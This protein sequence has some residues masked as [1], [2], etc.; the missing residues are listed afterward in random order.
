M[1]E[2]AETTS[3]TGPAVFTGNLAASPPLPPESVA[4]ANRLMEAGRLFRYGEAGGAPSEAALLEEE[5]AALTGG[6]YCVAVNSCGCALF[7][8]LA[9]AGAT[10]GDKVLLNAFTLAPAVGAIAHLGAE[11]VLVEVTPDLV[12]DIEDLTAKAEASGAKYLLLSY[13]RGHIPDMDRVMAACE[14][15][16]ITVIEDCAHATMATWDGKPIGRFGAAGCFSAQGYKHL[17]GGEGGLIVTEDADLA[18]RAILMSGSYMLYAQHRARPEMETMARWRGTMPN[19]SMRMN[20]LAAAVL[21]PQLPLLAGRVERWREIH[22]RIAA[23][24]T[25]S[26]RIR[27]PAPDPRAY[28]APTSLQFLL[29][30]MDGPAI[31]AAVAAAAARGVAIKWFGAAEP[32]GFTSRPEHWGFLPPQPAPAATEAVLARLC[33]IRLPVGLT[34]AECDLIAGIVLDAVSENAPN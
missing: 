25:Q 4:A 6:R 24:L 29:E 19:F 1:A 9:A 5:F 34:D 10:R 32:V 3:E 13:M 2:P 33:D 20:D 28:L 16:G 31:E 21:R 22:G 14:T 12:I 26:N 27:L 18:A 8:A 30:E 11:P 17:N 15:A 23:R 7:L